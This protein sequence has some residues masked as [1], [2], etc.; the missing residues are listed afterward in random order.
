[1]DAPS[2]AANVVDEAGLD[3]VL[4]HVT[5]SALIED[6]RDRVTLALADELVAE[7]ELLDAYSRVV[8]PE[9]SA[10]LAVYAPDADP[11]ATVEALTAAFE[12][13]G[14]PDEAIPDV[15]LLP[16]PATAAVRAGLA[17]RADDLLTGGAASGWP[18]DGMARF[19]VAR[20]SV[21]TT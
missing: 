12:A 8:G 3:V 15:V 17:V 16:L 10:T 2:K 9:D 6:A 5:P 11:A 20:Q 13:A 7:P 1:M 21:A 18:Y 19:A 14:V 4:G